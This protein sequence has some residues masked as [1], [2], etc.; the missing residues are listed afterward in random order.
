MTELLK[1]HDGCPL[2]EIIEDFLK[3]ADAE[4][5]VEL[6]ALPYLDEFKLWLQES[7]PDRLSAKYAGAYIRELQDAYEQLYDCVGINLYELLPLFISSIPKTHS[8]IL[9]KE[10]APKYHGY[11]QRN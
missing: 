1:Y 8:S 10:F 9:T 11:A 7:Y 2:D 6:I 5:D 4:C 3:D